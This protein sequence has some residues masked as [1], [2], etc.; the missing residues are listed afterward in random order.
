MHIVARPYRS[1]L[2]H[3]S[4]A[5]VATILALVAPTGWPSEILEPLTLTRSWP[6]SVRPSGVAGGHRRRRVGS[7]HHGARGRQL[8]GR[9][10]GTWMLVGSDRGPVRPAAHFDRNDLLSE[11]IGFDRLR[12]ALLGARSERVLGLARYAIASAQVLS[13]LDHAALDR[14]VQSP[15]GGPPS[16][17]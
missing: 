13:G 3:I 2:R 11:P 4:R 8:L 10:P 14:V 17:Q 5:S 6:A 12:C 9:G 15:R 16:C 7:D 1:C